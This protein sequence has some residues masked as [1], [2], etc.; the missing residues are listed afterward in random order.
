MY[1]KAGKFYAD[2]RQGDGTRRRKS[3]TSK[4][5]ALQFET[6]Q[7]EIAHPKMQAHGTPSPKSFAPH[8][9]DLKPGKV[10]IGTKP[11]NRSSLKL[12]ASRRKN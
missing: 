9:S 4:R 3:F 8:S 11:Q 1:E 10:T 7:K 5:A 6:E 2:W 12:V